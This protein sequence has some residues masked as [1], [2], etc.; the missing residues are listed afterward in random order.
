[1]GKAGTRCLSALEHSSGL[2]AHTHTGSMKIQMQEHHIHRLTA[3]D[4]EKARAG[5]AAT[6]K[7]RVTYEYVQSGR[8]RQG[9]K[10]T[11]WET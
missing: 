11:G 9:L 8:Q 5:K 6:W 2:Q 10:R 7:Q 3:S 4:C 1:M